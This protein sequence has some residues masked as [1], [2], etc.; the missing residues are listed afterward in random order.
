MPK[1]SAQNKLLRIVTLIERL[2]V[3]GNVQLRDVQS[4]LNVAQIAAMEAEWKQQQQLRQQKKPAEILKYEKLLKTAVMLHGKLDALSG[5]RLKDA[6]AGNR[7]EALK[8]LSGKCSSAFEDAWT[9]LDEIVSADQ[10]LRI[11]FDR[12]IDFGFDTAMAIDPA[13]M[14]RVITSRSLDNVGS[15][16]EVFGWKTKKQVQLDALILAKLALENA[17]ATNRSALDEAEFKKEQELRSK[18]TALKR[19]AMD[20]R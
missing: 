11:W 13:S 20:E 16:G 19:L 5:R 6:K 1:L 4:V 3:G 10:G 15:V 18:L 8:A 2:E 14:P 12:D 7:M 9:Y 17:L